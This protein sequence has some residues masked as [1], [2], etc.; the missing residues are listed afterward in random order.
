[1][2]ILKSPVEEKGEPNYAPDQIRNHSH[3]VYYVPKRE[4]QLQKFLSELGGEDTGDCTASNILYAPYLEREHN[5][6]SD[7]YVKY[8][9]QESCGDDE[10]QKALIVWNNGFK[11]AEHLSGLQKDKIQV[12]LHIIHEGVSATGGT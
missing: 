3:R 1:M 10:D 5:S 6:T 12:C 4:E 7:G 11:K 2:D 9:I 8:G